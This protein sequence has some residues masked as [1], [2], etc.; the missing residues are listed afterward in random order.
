VETIECF[1]QRDGSFELVAVRDGAQLLIRPI[2]PT[3]AA[4]LADG[5]DQLSIQSRWFRYRTS[6][7]GLSSA[8]LRYFHRRRRRPRGPHRPRPRRR[9]RGRRRSLHPA[10]RPSPIA[11]LAVT[12]VDA[13]HRRG[14]ATALLTRLTERAVQAGIRRY[15]ASVAADNRSVLELVRGSGGLDPSTAQASFGIV[16]AQITT[17]LRVPATSR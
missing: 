9:T 17:P 7:R 15:A 12:V 1:M 13:W 4:L 10:A 14:V 5:F 6:T 8:E 3:D 2:H 11:D 16:E